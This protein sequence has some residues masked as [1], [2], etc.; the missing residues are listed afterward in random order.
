MMEQKEPLK[1]IE[2]KWDDGNQPTEPMSSVVIASSLHLPAQPVS[3]AQAQGS[4]A[5]P[6]EAVQQVRSRRSPIPIAV[7]TLL[8]LVQIL[9]LLRFVLKTLN[10][11]ADSLLVQ[12]IYVVSGVF[13]Q[14]FYAF[15]QL[16][17]VSFPQET[18]TLLALLIY[19]LLARVVIRFLKAL[20]N[21]S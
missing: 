4:L 8:L 9:L 13:A 1:N 18:Y 19:G 17:P 20:L 5:V 21:A 3:P 6:A 2:A 7:G 11:P 16:I 10:V 12:I 14:P 15:G